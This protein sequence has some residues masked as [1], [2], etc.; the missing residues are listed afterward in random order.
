MRTTADRIT[1]ELGDTRC[2]EIP[3]GGSS[4][5][6]ATG[7][8]N[9]GLE[10]ARQVNNNV[11]DKPDVIYLGC[12]TAGSVAGLALGLSLADMPTSIQAVQVT[13]ESMQPERLYR[14]LFDETNHE[15]HARDSNVALCSVGDAGVDVRLDQL[16]DGYAMPT[17]ICKDAA[18]LL[19]RTAKL[20]ASL[21]YTGKTLAGLM[22][23]AGRG[24]LTGKNVVFWNT[25]NSNAY[26]EFAADDSWQ[27]LPAEMHSLFNTA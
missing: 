21:T 23:D 22:A 14:Q 26:P 16:G 2:Y 13:P 4:W 10:L 19:E 12:G 17:P 3:L 18:K 1:H 24:V 8:V 15:L 5:V 27:R 20:P 25:Y 9:A 11:L 7:F 6:G